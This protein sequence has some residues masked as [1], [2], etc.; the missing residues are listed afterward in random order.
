MA[1]WGLC[2]ISPLCNPH[3]LGSAAALTQSCQRGHVAEG[4][5]SLIVYAS[6]NTYGTCFR[7]T[8]FGESHGK[9]VGCVI[10]GVP[11]RLPLTK[12]E[13]QAEL[14]RRKPGQSK[15]TTPRKESDTC[16]IYSGKFPTLCVWHSLGL[17]QGIASTVMC[18]EIFWTHLRSTSN[19]V[20]VFGQEWPVQIPV[21]FKA[22]PGHGKLIWHLT[23][24]RLCRKNGDCDIHVP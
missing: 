2:H 19:A 9:G 13:I 6:G 14:D 4:R 5:R 15:I 8:T 17:L 18:L 21:H 3:K 22:N 24:C 1:N 12:A 16:D 10:D 20:W 11:P 23:L 7:V